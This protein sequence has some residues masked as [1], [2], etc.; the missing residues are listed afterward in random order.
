M[1][2]A[3]T[4]LYE[5]LHNPDGDPH[6]NVEYVLDRVSEYRR[7]LLLEGDLIREAVREYNETID[8]QH[9]EA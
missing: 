6:V 5:A 8:G 2:E 9:R 7:W 3:I 1:H 4:T